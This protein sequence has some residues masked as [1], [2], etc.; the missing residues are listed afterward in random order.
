MGRDAWIEIMKH[1]ECSKCGGGVPKVSYDEASDLLNCQCLSCK[2][3]WTEE[4]VDNLP[5]AAGMSEYAAAGSLVRKLLW[6]GGISGT[7]L[8]G[9]VGVVVATCAGHS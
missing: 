8:V 3:T 4:T 9:M 7:L 5:P 2:Y 6:V 1:R